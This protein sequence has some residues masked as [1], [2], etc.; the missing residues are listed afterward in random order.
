MTIL[1]D[2]VSRVKRPMKT[3]DAD[4][5]IFALLAKASALQ[6]T[7]SGKRIG[8]GQIIKDAILKHV[9]TDVLKQAPKLLKEQLSGMKPEEQ[10]ELKRAYEIARNELVA[11]CEAYGIECKE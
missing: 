9:A 6:S 7:A 8:E 3:F 5:N 2:T 1:E 4:R 10:T 11:V